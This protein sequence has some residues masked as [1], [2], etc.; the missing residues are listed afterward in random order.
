M[1]WT[2]SR[3]L[4]VLD[5]CCASYKFPMLDN[6]YLY[7]AATRLTL[8]RSDSDWGLVIE[9]FGHS[10]RDGGPSTHIDSFASRLHNR[11]VRDDYRDRKGYKMYLRN[12]PHNESRFA[13]PIDEREWQD[14]VDDEQVVA[15]KAT[16]VSVRGQ[17]ITIPA[18]A[19]WEN[20]RVR[21]ETPGTPRGFELCRVLASRERERVLATVAERRVSIRPEMTQILQ[22]EEWNHPDIAIDCL[23][24]ESETFQQLADVLVTGNL[25]RYAPTHP[26]NTHWR[27]WPT[28]GTLW[29]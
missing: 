1:R 14:L 7:L 21:L 24:S 19:T 26:S 6:G 16:T 22:L 2:G 11:D 20:D 27:N 9:V 12:N 18:L 15:S 5:A 23:P 29:P 4:G 25:D 3:I 28:G 17:Q 8:F 13:E 10:P